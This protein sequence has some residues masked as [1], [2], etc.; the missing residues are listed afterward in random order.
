MKRLNF[1]KVDPGAY[2]AMDGLETYVRNTSIAPLQQ[3]LIRIRVS[4]INGCS[5]C[6]DK[7][8]RDALKDGASQQKVFL[9]SAWREAGNIFSEEERVLLQMAEEITLISQHGL[10]DAVYEA[11]VNLFGEKKTAEIIMIIVT[12]NAWTR[13]GVSIHLNPAPVR[14]AA[15][16][17]EA[18]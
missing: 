4:Q 8:S 6:V 1:N 12:I 10:S 17:S 18:E 3:E 7:H 16:Q 11:A 15:I 14:N 9:V 13:I 2:T 5:Y